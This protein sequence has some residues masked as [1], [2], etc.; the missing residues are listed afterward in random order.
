MRYNITLLRKDIKFWLVNTKYRFRYRLRRADR[1]NVFCFIFRPEQA[2]AGIAD[3]LKAVISLYNL[4]KSNGYEF[5]LYFE[6]PFMLT[7]YLHAKTGWPLKLE[8]LEYSMLDTKIVN[9]T[10]WHRLKALQPNK[11]YHCYNYAGNDLPSVFP[12]TGYR[13]SSLFHELFEPSRK[14]Q[15]AYEALNLSQT[16]Y[17]SV[18]LRFV[19]ALENFEKTF[20][21][22]H[23]KTE[24]ERNGLIDK[25]QKGIQ[26]IIDDN[27]DKEVYVFSDSKIFLDS[28]K[29][30]SVHVLEHK[31][32]G[33][34]NEVGN[35][36]AHLKAFLDLYVMSK[37]V[38]VYRILTPEL[39]QWSCYAML[40]ARIGDI[41][42][43]EKRI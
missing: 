32:I 25:C 8:E 16:P 15:D 12:N 27:P 40:A 9:E 31:T 10:N 23:L 20:F 14:L 26:E 36:D 28:L 5:K 2:H 21:E 11:Q 1:R 29:D 33:H 13:W 18:H 30:M 4:T 35:D 19:N 7:D 37:S 6:T 41:P 39:Y 24:D 43:M 42:F 34:S 22:N 3:R 17:V 38:A